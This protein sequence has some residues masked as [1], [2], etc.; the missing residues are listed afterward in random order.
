MSTQFMNH[1]NLPNFDPNE[2]P[3]TIRQDVL[4]SK[5]DQEFEREKLLAEQKRMEFKKKLEERTMNIYQIQRG[6]L[7]QFKAIARAVGRLMVIRKE[8]I[9]TRLQKRA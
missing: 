7:A 8:A 9:Q 5:E 3:T 1:L 2:N 6:S 4:K